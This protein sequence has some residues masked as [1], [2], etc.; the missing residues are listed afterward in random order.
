MVFLIPVNNQ[1]FQLL[2]YNLLFIQ[3]LKFAV[4]KNCIFYRWKV[5]EHPLDVSEQRCKIAC[6]PNSSVLNNNVCEGNY[7]SVEATLIWCIHDQA[8]VLLLRTHSLRGGQR[9]LSDRK[10][11]Y[12]KSEWGLERKKCVRLGRGLWTIF[13]LIHSSE[14]NVA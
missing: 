3:T 6:Q 5:T 11:N 14:K 13:W 12:G 1:I 2:M 8:N 9:E 4:H 7:L 10:R